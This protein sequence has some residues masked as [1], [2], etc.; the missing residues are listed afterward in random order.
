MTSPRRRLSF[1]IT[2]AALACA[3]A[4]RAAEPEPV[5][6]APAA[7]STADQIDAYLRTSPALALPKDGP[8]GVTTGEEPRQA[9]GFVDLS[10]GSGGYRSAYVQSDLPVGKT[11]TLSIGIGETH[12]KGRV[13]GYGGYGG[14]GGRFAPGDRQS[15]ALGLSLGGD[16]APDA[17][18]LRAGEERP[19]L[20]SDPRFDGGRPRPCQPAAAQTHQ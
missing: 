4:P 1:L 16:A 11:G 8:A 3:G 6:T 20:R 15:L 19:D 17:R 7:T 9:H 14:Y 12:F 10:V 13:G 18:C 5:A 2:A